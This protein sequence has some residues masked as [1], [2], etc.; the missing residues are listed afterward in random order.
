MKKSKIEFK[1]IN[2]VNGKIYKKITQNTCYPYFDNTFDNT[3]YERNLKKILSFFVNKSIFI[4]S[5]CKTAD[6]F[7]SHLRKGHSIEKYAPT[8]DEFINYCERKGYDKY[9]EK[10]LTCE[11]I[12]GGS[13]TGR[14]YQSIN[15]VI[16]LIENKN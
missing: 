7:L 1:V 8:L 9:I 5:E 15:Y 6:D 12:P 13:A 14:D 10:H 4:G 2:P 3:E 16:E 11:N